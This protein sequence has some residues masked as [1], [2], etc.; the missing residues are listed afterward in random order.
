MGSE[1][2]L[3]K[4]TSRTNRGSDWFT[5]T[6]SP[7]DTS[8]IYTLPSPCTAGHYVALLCLCHAWRA[9]VLCSAIALPNDAVL[10]NALP[11]LC[12]AVLICATLRLCIAIPHSTT[13]R[14]CHAQLRTAL[15]SLCPTRRHPAL[16]LPCSAGLCSTFAMLYC[17]MLGRCPAERHPALPCRA[18]ALPHNAVLYPAPPLP[19]NALPLLR[20]AT[21]RKT[22][23]CPAFATPRDTI[24]IALPSSTKRDSAVA[25]LRQQLIQPQSVPLLQLGQSSVRT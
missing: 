13:P 24:A 4:A 16:L 18:I 12:E 11:S 15:P 10:R 3:L 8:L 25:T 1:R 21:H 9:E 5:C 6:S 7:P 2:R 19:C 23:Q 22:T 20:I 14:H 17:A